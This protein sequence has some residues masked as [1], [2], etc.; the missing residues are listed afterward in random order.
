MSIVYNI[1]F[2]LVIILKQIIPIFID[3][4]LMVWF[5]FERK[6]FNYS[7]KR[8]LYITNK[9][10]LYNNTVYDYYAK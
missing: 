1:V 7:G 8:L 10:V 2:V 4:F 9:T 5:T 6:V 3:T